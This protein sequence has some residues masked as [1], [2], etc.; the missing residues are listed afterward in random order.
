MIAPAQHTFASRRVA[1]RERGFS[2]LE[3]LVALIIFSIGMLGIASLQANVLRLNYGAY[4]RTQATV[5]AYNMMDRL[6]TNREAAMA[7]DCNVAL[8]GTRD[9]AAALASANQQLT[10]ATT[11]L[12]A[13]T[14]PAATQAAQVVVDAAQADVDAAAALS[15]ICES[16]V[17]GWQD[18]VATYLT[19]GQGSVT[20][21][22]ALLFTECTVEVEWDVSRQGGAVNTGSSTDS[23]SI[24]TSI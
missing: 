7:G 3:V 23:V 15:G 2:L 22:S 5:L 1:R 16:D 11:A 18:T 8:G 14:T 17:N 13:A 9:K 19:E 24:V 10:T 21:S 4:Q 20:C 12:S 6:R